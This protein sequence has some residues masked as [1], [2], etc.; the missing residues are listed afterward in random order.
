M[1][2][3]GGDLVGGATAIDG[4]PDH[5]QDRKAQRAAQLGARL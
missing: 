5:A 2:E 4:R 1:G 3:A